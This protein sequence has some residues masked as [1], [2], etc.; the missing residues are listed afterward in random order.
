VRRE[1]RV[2]AGEA[3]EMLARLDLAGVAHHPAAGL[4]YGTLKRVELARALCAR[5]RLLMLDEPASGLNHQEVGEL[6]DLLLEL[7]RELDLTVLLVEHHMGMV[8]RISDR[9]VVLNF[10]QVIAAG[11]PDEVQ[12]DEAVVTAY[13]GERE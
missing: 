5:P 11:S 3:D 1:E 2:L 12:N 8:M 6:G 10:G 4:S 9:V 13:L 7:R